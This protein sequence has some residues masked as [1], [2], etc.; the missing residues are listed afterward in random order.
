MD[1]ETAISLSAAVI[2]LCALF[3]TIWQGVQNR[4][5]NRL[6]MRPL[7]HFDFL[8]KDGIVSI[9]LKNTGVGPAV[10]KK[11]TVELD[12][13][14]LYG[15]EYELLK[16]IIEEFEIEHLGGELYRPGDTGQ[17]L[18]V[19]GTYELLRVDNIEVDSPQY[20]EL[21]NEISRVVFRIN[22]ESV[23][24]EKFEITSSF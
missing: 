19:N 12:G 11:F 17:G 4:R 23:Y 14:E 24:E 3:V 20:F 10:I 7:L 13:K 22:Y 9:S 18:P 2:A 6:S 8:A 5:H 1:S 16:T 21:M 15:N